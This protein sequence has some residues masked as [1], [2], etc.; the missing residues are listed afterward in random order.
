MYSNTT[1]IYINGH[2]FL[3]CLELLGHVIACFGKNWMRLTK[4]K[5][6]YDSTNCFRSLF[7][8]L[9]DK[10]GVVEPQECEPE[11]IWFWSAV[12]PMWLAILLPSNLLFLWVWYATWYVLDKLCLFLNWQTNAMLVSFRFILLVVEVTCAPSA[13]CQQSA[14]KYANTYVMTCI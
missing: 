12:Y 11:H 10:G 5:Q 4:V 7:W 8:L 2:Q 14:H 9:N 13:I 1:T 3:G 6:R